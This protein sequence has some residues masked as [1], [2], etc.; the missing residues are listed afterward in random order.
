[1]AHLVYIKAKNLKKFNY[2]SFAAYKNRQGKTVRLMDPDGQPMEKW[3][4][5][6]SMRAFDLDNEYD[7][8]VYEYL[9]DHPLIKR[10]GFSFIDA[11]KNEEENAAAAI[12]SAEA[13]TVATSMTPSQYDDMA[14]LI[15][16]SN[17]FD[18]VVRKAKVLQYAN[19]TPDKFLE[20]YNNTDKDYYVFLKK[21][22]EK[23]LIAYV[24][25][26]WKHGANSIGLT[27]EAAIEWLKNNKDVYALMK[28]ELRGNIVETDTK[29][30]EESKVTE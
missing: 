13:V 25:G 5:T 9:K 10:G 21:A 12:A 29:K 2:A 22:E 19:K 18:D 15:G 30:I 26:V 23:K 6:Q 20:M 17:N 16:L 11:R 7:K 4:L 14:R 1:M 24:N 8:R 28:S 3:E 27:D